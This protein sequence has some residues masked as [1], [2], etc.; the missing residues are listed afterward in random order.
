MPLFN[1]APSV[2]EVAPAAAQD[3][4][5]GRGAL[6]VDV[7]EADERAEARIPD[8]VH[9]PLAQIL[10]RADELP[11]DRPLIIQCRSGNRS[12]VAAE[13]LLQAGFQAVYN[14]KG[15][16]IAWARE[17]KPVEVGA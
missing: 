4:L 14:L 6:M 7:R 17:G 16:I 11:R 9:I 13:A 10:E 1:A 5:A 2:P 8:T 15:G 12:R 3:L